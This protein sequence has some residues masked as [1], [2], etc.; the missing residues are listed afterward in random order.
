MAF[1][2]ICKI[3]KN[4]Q[5][6]ISRLMNLK[7]F[8]NYPD[9]KFLETKFWLR[10]GKKL[11]LKKP[12]TFNEKLQWLKLYDRN[13]EYTQLVD[14]L[15]VRKYIEKTIGKEYLIPLLGEWDKF[16]DIDFNLLPDQFVL[17]C[18]HDSGGLIVCEDKGALNL[19]RAK[20]KINRSLKRNFYYH[21]REW[22]YKNVKPRIICEKFMV[23]ESGIELKDYKIFCFLG[24]PKIIQVDYNRFEGHKRNL[25]DVDWNYV[26]SSI[27]HPTDPARLIEKPEKLEEMLQ[28]ARMLSKE[29]YHVRVDFYSIKD[30]IYFGE[31]TFYHGSGYEKFEPEEFGYKMG[32]WLQ[33]PTDK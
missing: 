2:K 32:S 9:D 20:K 31:M 11:D 33:L 16:E 21:G 19:K 10:T 27:K 1:K 24:E 12:M 17:K 22:P 15:E 14:K 6:I 5:M 18:T 3:A 23:D 29:Y 28:L 7:M 30:K 4:P 8:N 25:Y 13:P 26:S